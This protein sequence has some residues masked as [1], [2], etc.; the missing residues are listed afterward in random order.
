MGKKQLVDLQINEVSGVDKAAN[1]RTFLV[2][3]SA[4]TTT[5]TLV[6]KLTKATKAFGTL[7]GLTKE[8]GGAQ[9]L[10]AVL[11]AQEVKES[12]WDRHDA[13]YDLF[14]PLMESVDSICDDATCVDKVTAVKNSLQQ[15]SDLTIASGIVK[16]DDYNEDLKLFAKEFTNI[17]SPEFIEKSKFSVEPT[18]VE[19]MQQCVDMVKALVEALPVN[20]SEEQGGVEMTPEE[21]KKAQDEAI[22]KAVEV[23]VAK[24]LETSATENTSLKKQLEDL[25]KS[26][27]EQ[28][29]TLQKAAFV[30]IAKELKSVDADETK[31]GDLLFKCSTKL[32]KAD[33]D[34]LEGI[35]KSAEGRIAEGELLKTCGGD[36]S[37]SAPVGSDAKKKADAAA[38][39][40]MAADPKLTKEQAFSKALSADPDLYVAYSKAING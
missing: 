36:G 39:T 25:Q 18:R 17:T 5:D 33:Y 38:A 34:T 31:L 10:Y 20:K 2:I 28:V 6:E 8:A 23:A 13:M 3:K 14:Y 35:L 22:Q 9:D 12:K 32:E 24:A 26:Q 30:S 1:L 29:E 37:G 40:L 27:A 15:F 11:Q 4:G 21:I 19:A 7:I 16:N